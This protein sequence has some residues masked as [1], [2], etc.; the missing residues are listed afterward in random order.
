MSQI[1]KLKQRLLS[2]PADFTFSEMTRLLEHLGFTCHNK[3]KTLGSRVLFHRMADGL[4]IV[5]H[6]PHPGDIMKRYAVD[7]VVK[8]LI[9]TGDFVE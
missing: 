8:T 4:S 9:E 6:K 3:G 7:Q 2:R 5:L 1:D